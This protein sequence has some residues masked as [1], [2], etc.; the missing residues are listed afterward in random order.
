[1]MQ[2]NRR[3]V[4]LEFDEWAD[5]YVR[6]GAEGSPSELHG[7]LIGS[8]VAGHPLTQ[9]EWLTQV[10]NQV[11]PQVLEASN[12]DLRR[13]F[14]DLYKEGERMFQQDVLSFSPMLPEDDVALGQRLEAI[15]AWC[16]GFIEGLSR[17]LAVSKPALSE[18]A[19]ELLTDLMAIAEI[20]PQVEDSDEQESYYAELV[21]FVR[22][23]A[24]NLYDE[25]VDRSAAP[26]GTLLH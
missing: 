6:L 21:E 26:S 20:D 24:M 18:D 25:F 19:R 23:A 15:G 3:A 10:T 7:A 14:E 12:E 4:T 1:M 9:V 5:I 22:V 2:D 16:Q 13:Q 8:L 11:G 17:G